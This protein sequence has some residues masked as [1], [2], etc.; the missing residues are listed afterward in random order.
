MVKSCLAASESVNVMWGHSPSGRHDPD[1]PGLDR[2][3]LMVE[4]YIREIT[5]LKSMVLSLGAKFK[6]LEENLNSSLPACSS[7]I[8]AIENKFEL[9]LK[10]L[11]D[12]M[13]GIFGYVDSRMDAIFLDKARGIELIDELRLTSQHNL[14][15][16][17]YILHDG[18]RV[19]QGGQ[20][21]VGESEG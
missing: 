2:F 8:T 9:E 7:K 19:G 12:Q 20:G 15:S 6:S 14:C 4:T 13:D 21:R 11:N 18:D 3:V 17:L 16:S 10:D 5:S 1:T